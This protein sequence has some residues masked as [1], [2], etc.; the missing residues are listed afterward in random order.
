MDEY[1]NREALLEDIEAAMKNNAMG[2][3]IGQ[4]LKRFVKRQT[5]AD[6]APVQ[7]IRARDRKPEDSDEMVLAIVYGKPRRNIWLV[8]AYY[9]ACYSRKEGWILEEYPEWEG[10]CVTH[11]MPL[12]EA[13]EK[14]EE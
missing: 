2:Y 5:A 13:P 8:G 6:V 7:W 1:I 11:W 3:A 10:A 4:T 9:L 12:P 14:E